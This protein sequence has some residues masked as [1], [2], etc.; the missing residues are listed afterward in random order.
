MK[1]TKEE[2]LNEKHLTEEDFSLKYGVIAV[3][4]DNEIL[5]FC[6]YE[7]K[8]TDSV[9][10]AL[11]EELKTTEEEFRISEDFKLRMAT[12]AEMKYY[13]DLLYG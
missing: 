5:H 7:E 4:S 9:L 8:P 3:N 11:E 12:E 13:M 1:I 10:K 2:L 6:G